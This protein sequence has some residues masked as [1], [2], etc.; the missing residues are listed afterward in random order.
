MNILITGG[1]GFL[2]GRLYEYLRKK[3]LKIYLASRKKSKITKK[4]D[5]NSQNKLNDLCKNKDII[6]NCAG[7]DSHGCKNISQ[8]SKINSTYPFR[9]FKAANKNNVKLFIFISTF[10]V[11]KFEKKNI[12]EKSKLDK[13]SIYTRSKILGEKKLLKFK[14]P[15]TKIIILRVCNLFGYPFFENK[16]C[17]RLL[18]NSIIKQLI[19]NKKFKIL[20][21]NNNYR[22]YSSMKSFCEFAFKIISKIGK[23]K[24]IPK[25]INYC[26]DKNMNLIQILKIILKKINNKKNQI[27]FKYPEMNKVKKIFYKSKYQSKFKS[28]NDKFF[29][30]ELKNLIIFS[31]KFLRSK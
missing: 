23:L 18:I 20:S 4:I 2:A 6:I 24:K 28:I 17:W 5:W 25:I 1:K 30:E 31:K 15:N 22:N 16:N 13:A 12:N 7:L 10:H 21:K 29:H 11:Y 27:F 9:L 19:I 3:N 26:S 8:A 14:N